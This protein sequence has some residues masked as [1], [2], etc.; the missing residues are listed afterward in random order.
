MKISKGC[1]YIMENV[2]QW[3][4]QYWVSW[5][6]ALIAGGIALFAKHYISI[7]KKVAEE[8]WKDKEKNM[9]GKIITNFDEKI[10]EVKDTS[11]QKESKIHQEIEKIRE[12]MSIKDNQLSADLNNMQSE[13]NSIENGILSIQGKQ[14]RD[15]CKNLLQKG[16]IITVDEYEDFETEYEVYKGLGGNH[17]GDALHDRVVEKFDKQN[18]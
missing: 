14:F 15:F 6:C 13:I 7:E 16:H 3:I 11:N 5:V 1:V 17:K 18:N 8:K 2:L 12:D 4:A 9:C 10:S